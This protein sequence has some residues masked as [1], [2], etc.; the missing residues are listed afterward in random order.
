MSQHFLLSASAR[1]LS[2]AAI[3]RMT[4]EDACTKFREIRWSETNGEPVCPRC[5][6]CVVWPIPSRR[7]WQCKAC[8]KQFSVTSGTIFHSRKLAI[9][10]YL[11]AIAIF[12]NAVKGV[13]ALQLGRDLDVSYRCAWVLAH[14]LRESMGAQVHHPDQPE[15]T[16]EI[17]VDG[18][19]FGG[20][21][22][23]ENRKADRRDR[24]HIV[25]RQVVAV[26]RERG[27]R[28][29]PFVVQREG[30]LIPLVRQHVASGTTVHADESGQWDRL[31][32]SFPA[33]RVNHSKEF[34][35]MDTGACTNMAESFFSRLR[36]AEFGQHHRLSGKFLYQY[37]NEAAWRE[38]HRRNPNGTNWRLVTAAALLHPKSDIWRGHWDRSR[39]RP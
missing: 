11:A 29:L 7:T 19:Y 13:S 33:L 28:T 34:K 32:A 35:D 18:A 24:R 1:S 22:R 31:H 3:L 16:G 12:V 9:R 37:V 38:D 20:S 36:R 27:G 39:V 25:N 26:I 8:G 6:G 30:D 15:M 10:D 23:Q 17:E 2:L 4:D 14:K 5:G 21:L